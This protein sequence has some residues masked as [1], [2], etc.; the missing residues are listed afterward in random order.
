M[1]L[2]VLLLALTVSAGVLAETRCPDGYWRSGDGTQCLRAVNDAMTLSDA[3]AYCASQAV[4][5]QLF[6][7][8]ARNSGIL[9]EFADSTFLANTSLWDRYWVGL[10]K[11]LSD[12]WQRNVVDGQAGGPYC[13][14]L[15]YRRPIN[16]HQ[17]S[18]YGY[19]SPTCRSDVKLPAIC[20]AEPSAGIQEIQNPEAVNG[21][22]EECSCPECPV[23][24]CPEVQC[25][26]IE[27]CQNDIPPPTPVV[28]C[29]P[30]WFTRRG[31]CYH[32]LIASKTWEE[33]SLSCQKDS[34]ELVT[35][36]DKAEN[37]YLAQISD[38]LSEASPTMRRYWIGLN[39]RD[40]EGQMRWISGEP[41]SF[42]AWG[43]RQPS[44]HKRR[45][46]DE[47]CVV[48]NSQLPGLWDDISCWRRHPYICKKAAHLLKE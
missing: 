3:E 16:A 25:P 15:D 11:D 8:M 29:P 5:G 43:P 2:K 34:A 9:K 32:F 33:A 40:E 24:A 48:I 22:V 42:I 10:T 18:F 46:Y 26:A 13:V 19:E 31:F 38:E 45:R 37:D 20:S 1:I 35:I 27:P 36:K 17:V 7:P 4:P 30:T 44:I 23:P 21:A 47:N 12:A 41:V 28:E 6:L 14:A 39:D